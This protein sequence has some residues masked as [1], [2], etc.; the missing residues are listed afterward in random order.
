MTYISFLFKCFCKTFWYYVS[1]MALSL[2]LVV[3]ALMFF[4][5]EML[6]WPS[7]VTVDL[8]ENLWSHKIDIAGIKLL[9]L[10]SHGI[11]KRSVVESLTD[12]FPQPQIHRRCWPVKNL[13]LQG[14]GYLHEAILVLCGQQASNVPN[15]LPKYIIN[16]DQFGGKVTPSFSRSS[17]RVFMDDLSE[18][19]WYTCYCHFM[20]L[21][22][23]VFLYFSNGL[24]AHSSNSFSIWNVTVFQGGLLTARFCR[25]VV[26]SWWAYVA[27]LKWPASKSLISSLDIFVVEVIVS[28][29]SL[30]LYSFSLSSISC[31]QLKVLFVQDLEY[32]L[33]VYSIFLELKMYVYRLLPLNPFS[34]P[35]GVT[36]LKNGLHRTEIEII[37]Y[38]LALSTTLSVIWIFKTSHVLHISH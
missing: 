6:T 5:Y 4:F 13:S 24:V 3:L 32:F 36:L 26:V 18:Q 37:I 21:F 25:H 22:V 17:C 33:E 10:Y 29:P 38:A 30:W 12:V 35:F 14:Y 28:S 20:D 15:R 2:T 8:H 16:H 31:L 7:H 23:I 27:A 19:Y 1:K 34:L 11:G 9:T